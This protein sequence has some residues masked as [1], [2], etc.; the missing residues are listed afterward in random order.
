MSE[1]EN[2]IETMGNQS[3]REYDGRDTET[4]RAMRDSLETLASLS[5]DS[6][7][8]DVTIVLW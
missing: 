1:L 7:Q 8:I 4:D 5:D 3:H 2:A 6:F